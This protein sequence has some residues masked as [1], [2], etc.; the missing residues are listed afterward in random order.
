M[1]GR[2]RELGE[3]V[4]VVRRS[5]GY[6]LYDFVRV[7]WPSGRFHCEEARVAL[8]KTGVK[9][10]GTGWGRTGPVP[11]PGGAR[12]WWRWLPN[13]RGVGEERA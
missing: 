8:E 6:A 13:E 10:K 7:R 3:I 11:S 12:G 9:V 5:V 1:A 4:G 2:R